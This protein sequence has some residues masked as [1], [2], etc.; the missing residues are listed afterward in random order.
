MR[1]LLTGASGYIGAHSV[2]RLLDEGH[3]LRVLIRNRDR[4]ARNTGS[5]GV[6]ID[7]LDIQFGD[8][9]DRAAVDAAAAGM[10]VVVHA[11]ADVATLNR[12]QAERTINV[13]LNGT[14]NVVGAAA[15]AGAERIVYLSSTA[16]VFDPTVSLLSSELPPAIDAESAYTRSKAL[17]EQWVREQQEAG[18]PVVSLY[19]GG[20]TGPAAGDAF[21]EVA[22]GTV[23]MLKAGCVQLNQGA[24]TV[25]DV[26]DIAEIVS[27]LC[28]VDPLPAQR[29]MA[30]GNFTT[31]AE[32]AQILRDLTGR[33]IP[34]LPIPGALFRGLGH[35]VDGVR[36]MVDFETVFTAEAMTFLTLAMPTDDRAV[37]DGLGVRYRPPVEVFE[38]SIRD[39][40][41]AG[42]LTDRQVGRL[43]R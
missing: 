18:V 26:R 16:A 7:A 24:V 21:G 22:Q 5:L 12:S 32:I 38:A 9:T 8:M 43:A 31:L 4:L 34:L 3:D 25:I 36:R 1:V 17:A 23:S 20:V 40:H 27:R 14:R 15:A 11:A 28:T 37:T 29:F 35:L 2:R 42:E 30:G 39:L 13:N 6:D 19:P 10:D 41:A 33:R